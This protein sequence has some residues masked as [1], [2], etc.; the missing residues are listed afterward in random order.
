MTHTRWP[1]PD[2]ELVRYID[3]WQSVVPRVYREDPKLLEEHVRQENSFRTSG[4]SRRQV[5]E[6][7]QNAA[8]AIYK[9]GTRGKIEL[10]LTEDHLYCA[11][12]GKAFERAGV[13]AI[14]H[15]YLSDKRGG[16][17]GRYG[18]GFK[19]VLAVSDNPQIFSRSA[20]FQFGSPA[21]REVLKTLDTA[22]GDTPVLRLATPLDYT[23][24]AEDDNV[25]RQ[26]A[27]WATTIVRLPLSRDAGLVEQLKEFQTQFLI[28]TPHVEA[29]TISI[30]RGGGEE[31]LEHTCS[32]L[33]SSSYELKGPQLGKQQWSIFTTEHRPSLAAREEVDDAIA[34]K[35]I[36]ITCAMPMAGRLG[37]GEFWANF[38]LSDHTSAAG[39][40]NAP[41]ALSED[42]SHIL[43]TKQ[44]NTE[45]FESM[46]QLFIDSL[47]AMRS[48]EQPARHLA[49]LPSRPQ[50]SHSPADKAL[51]SEIHRRAAQAALIP[52]SMG[53]LRH[54]DEIVALNHGVILPAVAMATW[55]A[56]PH[57]RTNVPHNSCYADDKNRVFRI[58]LRE[59]HRR[60]FADTNAL[61]QRDLPASDNEIDLWEWLSE[62]GD[63]DDVLYPRQALEMIPLVE[64][65]KARTGSV[66]AKIVPT[67]GGRRAALGEHSRLFPDEGVAHVA[68]RAGA[69]VAG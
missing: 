34:R 19:S 27:T 3:E 48:P 38:P 1:A 40:F 31:T 51:I 21:A 7:V 42:R 45:I 22:E 25:L 56:A 39:I 59:L 5:T 65:E 37:E 16:E 64:P 18:L 49:Y 8:D 41:W 33:G 60:A 69:S 12:D 6:L 67:D 14:T 53:V 50:E 46:A 17:I 35:S 32:A 63:V 62:L 4:Y 20:S 10:V 44:Y 54:G 57:T 43:T 47:P 28:F 24:A 68:R 15:A 26:L 29:L 61:L 13:E 36:L 9:S 58:R 2:P 55:S 30:R 11:N 52:D 23:V 66:R